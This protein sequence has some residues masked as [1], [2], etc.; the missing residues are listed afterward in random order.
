M[1]VDENILHFSLKQYEGDIYNNTL[2][3]ILSGTLATSLAFYLIKQLHPAFALAITFFI[4]F[5]PSFIYK[6][7]HEYGMKY[8]KAKE[9]E[10]MAM[11]ILTV[12]KLGA[13]SAH[14]LAYLFVIWQFS[15]R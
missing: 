5:A 10:Y 2:L 9:I 1:I 8:Y 4:M 13:A 11:T 15:S 7:L 14:N 6:L 3:L 12:A